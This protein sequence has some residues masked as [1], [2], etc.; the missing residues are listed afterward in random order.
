MKSFK[1]HRVHPHT[2]GTLVFVIVLPALL[3][4]CATTPMT[5]TQAAPGVDI[6]SYNTFSYISP[7]GTDRS[8]YTSFLSKD[9]MSATKAALEAKGYRYSQDAPKMLVN[10][11]ANVQQK[12]DIDPAMGAAVGMGPWGYRRGLYAGWGGYGYPT[13]VRQYDEGTL[14]IDLVD[15]A[16]KEMIWEGVSV[17]KTLDASKWT[18]EDVKS[19]VQAILADL[20]AA[21]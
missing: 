4:A 10:F 6:A 13:S 21:N 16:K 9:L 20:P 12:T 15:P 19:H 11:N 2:W 18:E 14:M 1:S 17:E 3:A 7:L 8:G 5:T